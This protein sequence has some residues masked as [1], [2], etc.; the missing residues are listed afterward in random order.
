MAFYI[1]FG[2]SGVDHFFHVVIENTKLP[3]VLQCVENM[4]R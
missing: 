4:A 1:T 3:A 2:V